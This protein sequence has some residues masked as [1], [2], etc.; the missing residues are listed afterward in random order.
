MAVNNSFL[1][2]FPSFPK[3]T[4]V[5]TDFLKHFL[6]S[7]FGVLFFFLAAADDVTNYN[8]WQTCKF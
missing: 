6:Q 2:H 8:R 4:A 1:G 7:F 5:R 3:V